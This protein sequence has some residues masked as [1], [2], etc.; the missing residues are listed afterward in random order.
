[1]FT[2]IGEGCELRVATK[3]E[4]DD[5]VAL[6]YE[7]RNKGG[8]ALF[9]FHGGEPNVELAANGLSISQ[10]IVAP[11]RGLELE[12]PEV[13]LAARLDPGQHLR[14]KIDLMLPL[15]ESAPYPHLR[16]PRARHEGYLVLDAWF[17]LGYVAPQDPEGV[18]AAGDGYLFPAASAK[19]QRIL[20]VGPIGRFAFDP[21]RR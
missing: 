16:P 20:R 9:G 11:P 4:S 7:L 1:M 12:R 14:G 2:A 17:E 15:R 5:K 13:P 19:V 6:Y 10:K 8:Q 21:A 18:R 3:R